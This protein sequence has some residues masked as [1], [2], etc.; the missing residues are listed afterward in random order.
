M[1]I[2]RTKL[3]LETLDDDVSAVPTFTSSTAEPSGGNNGDIWLTY[4][5]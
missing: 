3:T 5:P 2:E 1:G 4:T